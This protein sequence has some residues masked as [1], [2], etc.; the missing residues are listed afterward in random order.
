[1][2]YFFMIL[3]ILTIFWGCKTFQKNRPDS[4][5]DF[6][7]YMIEANRLANNEKYQSAI[8]V[9]K[10]I[11]MKFP[12]E[13]TLQ[14]NYNIGFNYY[15][16]KRYD[17]AKGYFNSVIKMYEEKESSEADKLENKKFVVLSNLVIDKIKND[18]DDMKD[19]YH[20]EEDI[21]KTELSNPK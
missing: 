16:M 18:I 6:E 9:L 20:I 2:R 8:D 19:P 17:E 15:K 3:S 12:T 21:I 1:M 4:T 10:E 7:K 14:V 5:W 11:T 13:S